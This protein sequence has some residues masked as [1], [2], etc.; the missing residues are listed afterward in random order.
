MATTAIGRLDAFQ[1]DSKWKSAYLEQ[2]QLFFQTNEVVDEKQVTV[3]LSAIG[4]KTHALLSDLLFP[5]K[6]ATKVFV[7]LRTC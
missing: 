3:L 5:E 2:V 1:P 4:G 6:P 7:Q